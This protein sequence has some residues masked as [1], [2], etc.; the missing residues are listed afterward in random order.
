VR[1]RRDGLN[2]DGLVTDFHRVERLLTKVLKPLEGKNLN[3]VEALSTPNPS[4][5]RMARWIADA[6]G[7]KISDDCFLYEVRVR[8]EGECWA[9]YFPDM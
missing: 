4:T 5:E 6:L 9:S 8:E 1:I 3:K 7:K 2:K